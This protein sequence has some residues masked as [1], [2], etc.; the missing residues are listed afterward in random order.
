MGIFNYFMRHDDPNLIKDIN[1]LNE[2]YRNTLMKQRA[3]DVAIGH[4]ARS[5]SLVE[6]KT[7]EKEKLKKDSLYYR[8]NIAPNKNQNASTFWEKVVKKLLYDD[9]EALILILKEDDFVVADDFDVE[10]YIVKENIYKHIRVDDLLFNRSFTESEVIHLTYENLQLKTILQELD[11]SYGNLFSRLVD[12]A[13]RTNQIRGTAK[14]T[15]ALAKN[16]KAVD[17]LQTFVDKLFK[18]FRERSVAIVATQDGMEY[19]ETSR[20]ANTRSIVDEVNKA[21]NQYLSSTLH[22]VGIHPA[23]I[24]G[25]MADVS[26]HQDNYILNVVQPLVDKISDEINRKFFTQSEHIQG[27]KVK[28]SIVKLRYVSVFDVGTQAEKLIGSSTLSPNEVREA[29]GYERLQLPGMDEYYLTK[30]IEVLTLKGGENNEQKVSKT[31]D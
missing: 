3:L 4:V 12:V 27:S 26:H 18:I 28:P 8:L 30:N 5:L 16:E 2:E 24:D 10:R 11:K 6:W 29:L 23:L 9:G 14:L 15:G 21:S 20:E 1:L 7:Y 31:H 25:D 17:F 13:M 22:A 19:T